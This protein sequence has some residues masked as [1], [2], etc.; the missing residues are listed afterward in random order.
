MIGLVCLKNFTA[1]LILILIH[2]DRKKN[3]QCIIII[4]KIYSLYNK[5]IKMY[6]IFYLISALFLPLTLGWSLFGVLDHA[7]DYLL[8]GKQIRTPTSL[9]HSFF[10]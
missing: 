8:H 7:F 6:L 9:L 5:I 10:S 3:W 4:N 1:N 2:F